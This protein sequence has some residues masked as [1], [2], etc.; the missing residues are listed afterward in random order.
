LATF[1]F[2]HKKLNQSDMCLVLLVSFMRQCK[3]HILQMTIG[4]TKHL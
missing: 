4:R 3:Q 2:V 1:G